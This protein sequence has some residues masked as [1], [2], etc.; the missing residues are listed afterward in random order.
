MKLDKNV[1][2]NLTKDWHVPLDA[3]VVDD[4]INHWTKIENDLKSVSFIDTSNVIIG[5]SLKWIVNTS[6][7][8]DQFQLSSDPVVNL[9]TVPIVKNNYVVVKNAI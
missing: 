4:L 8:L 5:N 2:I 3:N 1:I 7:S 6:L 9:K